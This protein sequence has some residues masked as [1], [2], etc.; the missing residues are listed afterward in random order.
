MRSV[1]RRKK[2]LNAQSG[3]HTHSTSHHIQTKMQFSLIQ[4]QRFNVETFQIVFYASFYYGFDW[5]VSSVG[6]VCCCCLSDFRNKHAGPEK[7]NVHAQKLTKSIRKHKL[8]NLD[9]GTYIVYLEVK[10]NRQMK[11]ETREEKKNTL[12][13][14]YI[15][16]SLTLITKIVG[17]PGAYV[18]TDRGESA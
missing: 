15:F 6:F 9:V 13:F 14:V 10:T 16:F 12:N 11:N 2:N 7:S 4:L 3:T 1:C 8:L 5:C 18:S 17:R